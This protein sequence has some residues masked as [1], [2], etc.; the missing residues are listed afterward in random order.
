MDMRGALPLLLLA[1]AP[2]LA[3]GRKDPILGCAFPGHAIVLAEDGDGFAWWDESAG[4]AGPAQCA[5][6]DTG[7]VVCLL[8]TAEAPLILAVTTGAAGQGA[9]FGVAKLIAPQLPPDGA[10]ALASQD[11]RCEALTP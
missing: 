10:L 6:L 8:E 2:S 4:L 1:A 7:A 11:G 3:E 9:P 5:G